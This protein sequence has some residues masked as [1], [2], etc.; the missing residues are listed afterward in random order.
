MQAR[1]G[2]VATWLTGNGLSPAD[3]EALRVKLRAD[4]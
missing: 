1:Y 2:G 3:L 4:A